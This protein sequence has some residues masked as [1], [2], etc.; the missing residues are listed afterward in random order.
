MKNKV[1]IM[2]A[3]AC[4]LIGSGVAAYAQSGHGG[5]G[6][7]S[8]PS[9]PGYNRMAPS[10]PRMIPPRENTSPRQNTS[11]S[12]YE[13]YGLSYNREKRG[14]YYNDKTVGLFADR[15]GRRI[16]FLNQKGEIHLKATRD[17]NGNLTGLAELSDAEYDEIIAE[18]KIIRSE[19]RSRMER[20][21]PQRRSR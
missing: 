1:T 18:I 11:M 13:K 16:T 2:T 19:L 20:T 5:S 14:Y 15:L 17:R 8:R 6:N 3:A 7:N 9:R 12:E 10:V 4:L 21:F